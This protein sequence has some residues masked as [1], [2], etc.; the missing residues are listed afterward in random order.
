M[1]IKFLDSITLE[2]N[3]IQNVAIQN[4]AADPTA[5]A[6]KYSGRIIFNTTSDTLKYYDGANWINLDGTGNVD[7]VT[8]SNGL[9]NANTPTVVDIEPDY[10]SAANIVLA[11]A[12]SGALVAASK[13]LVSVGEV[14]GPYTLTQL[15]AII[16]PLGVSSFTNTNGTFIS[17]TT[18]NSTAIGAVTMGTIDLS[19]TGTAGATTFLRGDNVWATPA[20]SYTSWELQGDGGPAQAIID[21]GEVKFVGGTAIATAVASGTPDTLTITHS[22]FGTPG[23]YAYPSSIVT[24]AQ[25]H[26]IAVTAGSAPTDTTYTLPV[27]AAASNAVTA[28]LTDNS[29]TVTSTLS[30]AGV[31]NET[32]V[33]S[34]V[35]NNGVITIG[36]PDD[37]TIGNDL[38]VT[39]DISAVQAT[40]TGDLTGTAATFSGQVTI[41]QVPS[42]AASAASKNYVDTTLAGSGA[43]IF[44]GGYNASAAPPTGAS[45]LK[46]FTYVVTTAGDGNGFFTTTLEI[47]DLIISNQDN[48]VDEDDWT[49]VQ[50]N[51]D[52]ATNSIEGVS[53]FLT[54]N[55]FA[56]SMVAGEPAIP[57]QTVFT[58]E[59]SASSVPVITTNAFGAVTAIT[60]TTI[61]IA[62]SQVTGFNAAVDVLVEATQFKASI[63]NGTATSYIVN[64]ALNTRDVIVQVYD[65][66]SHETV[67]C[68]VVRTDVNNV[69]I[70]TAASVGV[71]GLRVVIQS[72]Q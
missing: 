25:G 43:L 41:P 47:G 32:T 67:Q 63:G 66:T 20:G 30:F 36:L 46:G 2:T 33:T 69:T 6:D 18:Q 15:G 14:V 42:A 5:A 22:N 56:G 59:G 3:E 40:L 64:H 51:I 16:N 27:T 71:A 50:S 23:T 70:S 55:G 52:K 54:A 21:G 72:L 37:V 58:T 26:V 10:T 62:T 68:K 45:V 48:P 34:V 12:G 57:A 60:D 39:A 8:A 24:N 4:L 49:E 17:A 31:A 29:S 44:Q 11:S 1:A 9:K 53:K 35:T 28:S 19:A 38:T 7:S 13:V 65:T 61:A